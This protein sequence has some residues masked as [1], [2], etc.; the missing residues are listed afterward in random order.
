M[1]SSG[2]ERDV[3]EEWA[4]VRGRLREEVGEAAFRSW[5]KPLTLVGLHNG[6][7]RLAVPT[8]FMR[9]WVTSN[10]ADRLRALWG[11]VD[12][13]LKGVEIIVR[14][15][16]TRAP[17]AGAGQFQAPG[18]NAAELAGD[19]RE[20]TRDLPHRDQRP[21]QRPGEPARGETYGDISAPLDPRFTFDSFVVGNTNELAYAAA[22]RVAEAD[23]VPFNPLF[24]Y[25]GVGLGKTHLMHAIA[26]HLR[27]R[28]P[29]KTRDL[30]LG[31][32]VHV[33]VH[34]RAAD[35]GHGRLQGAVPL[36]RRPDDRRRSVHRRA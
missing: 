26:W 8:R 15:T 6:S 20:S 23:A 36:G 7:V 27:K 2:V 12:P 30:S 16:P 4:K 24:L 32:E 25:G 35:Q 3:S 19:E 9:D 31:R 29:Q 17:V 10:Y 13:S 11:S 34:P 18:A 21:G 33:P 22:R 14:T 1:G 5:L 28:S